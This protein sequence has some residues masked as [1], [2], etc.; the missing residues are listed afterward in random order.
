M[1]T[2]SIMLELM[3]IPQLGGY[4]HKI[5]SKLNKYMLSFYLTIAQ[6]PPTLL[7]RFMSS[8][9]YTVFRIVTLN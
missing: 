3:L 1:I 5:T 2:V 6:K 8:G 9:G 7:T 4:V